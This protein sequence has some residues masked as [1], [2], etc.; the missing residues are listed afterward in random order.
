MFKL[1][2]R[3]EKKQEIRRV[4]FRSV[5]ESDFHGINMLTIFCFILFLFC[6]GSSRRE[7]E[8]IWIKYNTLLKMNLWTLRKY[9][10][11][12]EFFLLVFFIA[13]NFAHLW[14]VGVRLL[15]NKRS[16]K[17]SKDRNG[18]ISYFY[19]VVV[20]VIVFFCTCCLTSSIVAFVLIVGWPWKSSKWK[21]FP[22]PW[23]EALYM[24]F[25]NF[26]LY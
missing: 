22:S 8:L 12:K 7:G 9:A 25:L 11:R 19:S 4:K 14:F 23:L 26:V 15:T 13:L 21:I 20:V 5:A 24:S 1:W 2:R 6:I 17:I 3:L 16:V 10:S 18:R